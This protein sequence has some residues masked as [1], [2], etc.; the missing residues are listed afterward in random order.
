M[1]TQCYVVAAAQA[2]KHGRDGKR[3]SHGDAMVVDPW[4]EVVARVKEG[5]LATGVAF[6]DLSAER[7]AEVRRRMPIAMHRTAGKK[8]WAGGGGGDVKRL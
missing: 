1:E 7:L 4:G 8:R 5:P 2:G 3:E 6:A